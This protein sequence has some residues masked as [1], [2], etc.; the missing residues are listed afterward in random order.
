MPDALFS[1]LFKIASVLAT[2]LVALM[3]LNTFPANA[4]D[5]K[6]VA[7]VVEVSIVKM[8]FEPQKITIK[9]GTTVKWINKEKRNN[10]S[11]FF[12][13]EG[14]PESERLFQDDTWQRTFDKPGVYP[15]I[16]GPHPHM[17]GEVVVE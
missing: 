7:N 17:T 2:L 15:Y 13:K 6:P 11:I 9:A 3:A 5:G 12:E 1:R 8:Q 14:L 10:H 4:S 16:C